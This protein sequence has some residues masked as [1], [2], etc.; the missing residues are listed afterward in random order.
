[1]N[2]ESNTTKIRVL[3]IEDEPDF[4]FISSR[5]LQKAGFDVIESQSGKE[6]LELVTTQKPDLI[7]TDLCLPVMDGFEIL[8]KIRENKENDHIPV[9]ALTGNDMR[10]ARQNAIEKGFDDFWV[11]PFSENNIIDKINII[12]HLQ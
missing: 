5:I 2:S 7:L 11:K 3:L 6:A 12:L 4:L 8:R 1:M 9:V 10:E